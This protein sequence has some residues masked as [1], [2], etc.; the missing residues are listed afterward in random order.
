MKYEAVRLEALD[1]QDKTFLI[2]PPVD[3]IGIQNSIGELGVINPLSIRRNGEKYQIICGWR[4]IKVCKQLGYDE[5]PSIVYEMDELSDED[6]LKFVLYEN[7][8]R[9]NEIDKAE[10]ILKFKRLCHFSD[11]DLIQKVLPLFGIG[12]T[13]K[14]LER[15]L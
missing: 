13:R 8:R 10:L 7:Q 4:R 9:L 1:F 5:I 14:N 15:C 2:S 3:Y 12:A 6:C 11:N